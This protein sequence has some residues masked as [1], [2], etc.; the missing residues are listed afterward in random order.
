MATQFLVGKMTHKRMHIENRKVV[1]GSAWVGTA[2]WGRTNPKAVSYLHSCTWS[3]YFMGQRNSVLDMV[4]EYMDSLHLR[5]SSCTDRNLG[6]LD[7]I[8]LKNCRDVVWGWTVIQLV[9]WGR[10]IISGVETASAGWFDSQIIRAVGHDVG[11][12]SRFFFPYFLVTSLDLF[13]LFYYY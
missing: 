3:I 8:T 7:F 2:R 10:K 11:D 4:N 12:Q 1:S 6:P 5:T 9:F 13:P